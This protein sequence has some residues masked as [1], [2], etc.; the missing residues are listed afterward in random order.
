MMKPSLPGREESFSEEPMFDDEKRT[1]E[2]TSGATGA[3]ADRNEV[4][5]VKRLAHRETLHIRIWRYIVGFTILGAGAIVS[6]GTYFY[7]DRQFSNETEDKFYVFANTIEDVSRMNFQAMIDSIRDLSLTI[8]AQANLHNLEFPFITVESWEV[9][10]GKARKRGFLEAVQY[11]PILRGAD[12]VDKFSLYAQNNTAWQQQAIETSKLLNPEIEQTEYHTSTIQPSK[13]MIYGGRDVEV[14]TGDGPFA[15]VYQISPPVKFDILMVDYIHFF[16]DGAFDAV[17]TEK[18]LLMGRMN[19][20]MGENVDGLLGPQLH[21]LLHAEI[22]KDDNDPVPSVQAH[23][24]IVQPVYTIMGNA[25]SELGGVLF[26]FFSLDYLLKDLLPEGIRGLFVVVENTC[27]DSFTYELAG[28]GVTYKGPGDLSDPA[29]QHLKR[30]YVFDHVYRDPE[31]ITALPHFCVYKYTVTSSAL[32]EEDNESRLPIIYTFVVATIFVLMA[33]AFFTYDMHVEKRN[34]KMVDTAAKSNALVSSIFPSNVRDRLLADSDKDRPAQTL[35]LQ[36]TKTHLKTFLSGDGAYIEHGDEVILKSKPIA[37]LF[38]ETTIMFGDISGF[39]A[40][41]SVREPSQ[42]FTLLETLYR[43]FDQAAA[44]RGVFKVETVGDCYVAVCGLP[45]PRSD[46]AVV[47]ARFARDCLQRMHD[48]T[49]KL[50]VILG[51]DTGELGMRIGLHSGPVTAGVLRGERSRFQLF[52][53]TM[54]T[55]SRMES[56]SEVNRIQLSEET[57]KLLIAAGKEHWI[58]AREGFVAAKGKGN[59]STFWLSNELFDSRTEN[60]QESPQ[61]NYLPHQETQNEDHAISLKTVRLISW[62]VEVLLG[63]LKKILKRKPRRSGDD[64][65]IPGKQLEYEANY[66]RAIAN[67]TATIL[68]EVEEVIA[69]PIDSPERDDNNSADSKAFNGNQDPIENEIS[70][71]VAD[72]LNRFVTCV[73]SMYNNNPFHNFE[74][75]SHVTMSVVKLLSRIVA[76]SEVDY[77]TSTAGSKTLHDHTYGI[78]SDP[79]TQFACVFSALI[80]DADHPGVPNAQLVNEDAALAT[81]YKGKSVAEQNSVQLSW[82]LLMSDAFPNLRGAIYNSEPEL[83]RFRQLI[84]NAVMATDIVDKEL[85]ALRNARWEKAFSQVQQESCAQENVN[86][87]ATIVIEHL[88]QASDV[89]HTM[90]H[91]HIYR[92][93]NE[94]FFME[95]YQAFKAGRAAADP[96]ENWYKGEIGFFDFYIIPLA[97]KLKECGVFGVSSDEYLNYATKNRKEWEERGQEI[98]ASMLDK[99]K[100]SDNDG[101]PSPQQAVTIENLGA[102]TNKTHLEAANSSVSSMSSNVSPPIRTHDGAHLEHSGR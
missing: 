37:D 49:G 9:H 85:K 79:L 57:A 100:Q 45:D 73:A 54:N 1:E 77:E 19:V 27:G 98:V 47:M 20:S 59:L 43:A 8:T 88:I 90:Q 91:W 53:D 68:D 40:W 31:H 15:P 34:D 71:V 50:E 56:T 86:R 35:S 64:D 22:H 18:E 61:G 24:Y 70:G 84:V 96:S 99:V 52:G 36:M 60:P 42:V 67:G 16:D 11:M 63:L 75:A 81:A 65:A 55:A 39:T 46:H 80:H 87:K 41:S 5:A 97:K 33:I 62:N 4:D 94:R 3:D 23:A 89:A 83:K 30:Q 2:D 69:L 44:K 26:A 76:P 48:L 101:L 32:Y 25:T 95:C 12:M 29:Y 10:A 38:T 7:L 28:N 13:V 102:S 72:E 92:K 14:A 6:L 58:S 17:L 51:P 93:W 78:T 74:H 66:N 82:D 21:N